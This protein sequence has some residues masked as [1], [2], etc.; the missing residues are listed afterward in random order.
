MK[1]RARDVRDD[2]GQIVKQRLE[3][4]CRVTR[5]TWRKQRS[6]PNLIRASELYSVQEK[7][8]QSEMNPAAKAATPMQKDAAAAVLSCH[9]YNERITFWQKRGQ[10][11]MLLGMGSKSLP[12]EFEKDCRAQLSLPSSAHFFWKASP[13]TS[14]Q[15]DGCVAMLESV[16]SDAPA[17][18]PAT[19]AAPAIPLPNAQLIRFNDESFPEFNISTVSHTI[20]V[21]DPMSTPAPSSK[22]TTCAFAS[23]TAHVPCA[24]AAAAIEAGG[25]STDAAN[26]AEKAVFDAQE[27]VAR[28]FA[29]EAAGDVDAATAAR[30]EAVHADERAC[31]AYGAAA[32]AARIAATYSSSLSLQKM[33]YRY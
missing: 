17:A 9:H 14:R 32:Q 16:A 29:A 25:I 22:A 12:A 20:N 19:A 21:A 15:H 18:Q 24:A 6:R 2:K 11:L 26:I 33:R 30:V 8:G 23:V 27:A 4:P 5:A 3:N 31:A 7:N 28:E 10:V 13:K 1:T